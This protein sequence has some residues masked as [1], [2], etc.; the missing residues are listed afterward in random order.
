LGGAAAE[1]IRLRLPDAVLGLA[2][3][4][5]LL[6]VQL[7][8]VAVEAGTQGLAGRLLDEP[9]NPDPADDGPRAREWMASL[10]APGRTASTPATG[11][12]KPR[13]TWPSSR[14]CRPALGL[15]CIKRIG[16]RPP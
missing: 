12:A 7:V 14:S 11:H 13:S 9:L 2:A 4:A 16:T 6:L 3:G 5:V 10:V 1:R 8:G 15:S